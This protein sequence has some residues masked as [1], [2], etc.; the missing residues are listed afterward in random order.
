MRDDNRAE[1]LASLEAIV[2]EAQAVHDRAEEYI[3]KSEDT[4]RTA[5]ATLTTLREKVRRIA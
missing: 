2:K 3:R 1:Y 4:L 5:K